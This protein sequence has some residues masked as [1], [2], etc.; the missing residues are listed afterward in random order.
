M[1]VTSHD[2]EAGRDGRPVVALISRTARLGRE[3]LRGLEETFRLVERHQVDG[4]DDEERLIEALAGAWGAVAGSET[5]SRRVMSAV[6]SLAVIAR[7]GVGYDAIDVAA[8]TELGVAV[9]T[10]P[11]SNAEAVAD[12]ALA[13][14]LACIRRL[15]ILDRTV[16]GGGWRPTETAGDLA[17]A[18]VGIVG[19]GSIGLAVARRLRGFG[20]ILLGNEP[21]PSPACAELGI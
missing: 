16:R 21:N 4:T 10:T 20:C 12:L 1:A 18:T 13:L 5:Y 17:G 11:G 15:T 14:M 2:A 19:L 9:C 3:Q 8:A 6:D 7:C